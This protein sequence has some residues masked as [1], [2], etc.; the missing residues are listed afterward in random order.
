MLSTEI[1]GDENGSYFLPREKMRVEASGSFGYLAEF[2]PDPQ[3]QLGND[4]E[5]YFTNIMFSMKCEVKT[6]G[7]SI[8]GWNCFI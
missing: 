7:R 6:E 3:P 4:Q 8:C 1:F 5:K 2:L